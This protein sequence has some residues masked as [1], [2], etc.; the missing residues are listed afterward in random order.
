MVKIE[1]VGMLTTI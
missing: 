1:S